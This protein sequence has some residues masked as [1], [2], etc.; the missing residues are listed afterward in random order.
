MLGVNRILMAA[1]G[2]GRGR[3]GANPIE[4]PTMGVDAFIAVMN[5]TA[6]VVR[7]TTIATTR[8]IDHLGERNEDHN[9]GHN[10]ECGG[11]G[12]DNDGARNHDNPMTLATFLKVNP[13]KFKG[14]LV[15]TE[16]DNWFR[17]IEKSLR[18]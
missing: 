1:R 13:P 10:G 2:R 15:A 12:N 11:D 5:T 17:G 14:T 16:V 7:E 9:G 6:E 4:E 18:A 3:H 8:A